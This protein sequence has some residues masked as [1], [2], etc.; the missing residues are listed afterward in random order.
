MPQTQAN[1]LALQ[2]ETYRA[3]VPKLFEDVD[4]FYA[5][6]KSKNVEK[7]GP[8][9]LRLPK[10][11][12]P[13]GQFRF[14]STDGGD[15]GRGS[16]AQYDVCTLTPLSVLEAIEINKSVEYNTANNE[17]AVENA[18]K[19]ALADAMDEF[20]AQHDKLLQTAGDGVLGTI[21]SGSATTTWVMAAPFGPRL[22]RIGSKVN[23][24]NAAL[25][26]QRTGGTTSPTILSI[27]YVAGTV[28]VD[29]NPTG[30]IDT[31][32]IVS[33]GLTGST[34]VG[35][36]G[37]P[38][39]HNSAST[40]T[41]MGLSRVTYPELRTP[42]IAVS[43]ALTLAPLRQIQMNIEQLRGP[44]VWDTGQ[45]E[46][47]GH[48]AQQQAYE[49]LGI[50][51]TEW[52]KASGNDAY[53]GLFDRKKLRI[54]GF[55]MMTSGNAN[56]TRLDLID[57]KNWGSGETVPVG[58]YDVEDMTTFPI[59][60]VSGGLAAATI[61]YLIHIVQYFVDDPQRAGYLSSLSKPSGYP[62]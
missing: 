55:R 1:V 9:T 33:E 62:Y 44:E 29:G 26:T 23:A 20:K 35:I 47:Y 12:R 3:I 42:S 54:G 31:D 16:A 40:G 8:R 19:D 37:L 61:F 49:E 27:D 17:I 32:V 58:L 15:M 13:G 2:K 46:W 53:D 52:D 39:H 57:W 4:A 25:T 5:R 14:F 60:G 56:P 28:T 51:V 36:F 11:I 45:W 10:K 6:V 34:P 24:Y 22:L 50:Q 30:L 48:Q 38:Y 43:A 41:Y 21:A 18:V 59:Y 7:A